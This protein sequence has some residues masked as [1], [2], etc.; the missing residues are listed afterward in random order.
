MDSIFIILLSTLIFFSALFSG[1]ETAFLS[2]DRAKLKTMIQNKVKN[3]EL[4]NRLKQEPQKLISTLLIGNNLV[5]IA[6]SAIATALCINYFGNYGVGI[7]TGIMTMVILFFGEIT[8]KT[9]ALSNAP[10]I[11][12]FTSPFI[13]SLTKLFK[14]LIWVS[15]KFTKSLTKSFGDGKT[16]AITEEE[17]KSF[18][19]IGEEI[20]SIEKDEKEMIDNIFK[21]NDIQINHIMVPKINVISINSD[22]KIK[23]VITKIIKCGHSRIPVYKKEKDK[24][25]G[26]LY[27]KDVLVEIA[28]GNF[29][30]KIEKIAR[31][32]FFVPETKKADSLLNE[33]KKLKTHIAVAINEYGDVTGIVTLEDILEEIVGEIY[34]ETDLVKIKIKKIKPKT[35]EI[36]GEA[37]LGEINK[38]IGRKYFFAKEYVTI[39]GYIMNK[40]S[41]IPKNKENIEF[42]K[43]KLK[44]VNVKNN[45]LNKIIMYIK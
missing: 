9:I 11:C 32:V 2:L 15:N 24:I 14:P 13:Y 20:G 44:I 25:V 31:E 22:K 7:A 41:R 38:G 3:A 19:S 40:L 21:M 17:I 26:I 42:K 30:K 6:A 33:F 39:S 23:D 18:I 1:I 4:V 34:D 10:A 37:T 16:L 28:R 43:F 5:N 29:D 27:T 36:D 35:Y 12:S 8:P 45:K